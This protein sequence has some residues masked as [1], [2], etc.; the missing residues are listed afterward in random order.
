VRPRTRT[1]VLF[2]HHDPGGVIDPYVTHY[3]E[4]LHQ[5]NTDIIFVSTCPVL[6]P[7]SVAPIRDLCAAIYTR[8]NTGYDFGSWH[9]AWCL[10]RQASWS[11]DDFDC[12]VLANDSVYGPLFPLTEM[13]DTFH[14][15][16][17]YG[18]IASTEEGLH[19][20]SFFLAFDINPKTRGFLNKFWNQ[21]EHI[22]AAHVIE[23]YELG[24]SNSARTAGLRIKPFIT[25]TA[26]QAAYALAPTYPKFTAATLADTA[27]LADRWATSPISCLRAGGFPTR[28]NNTIYFWDG[29]IEHLR[30]PF[31]KTRIPR[32]NEPTLGLPD[33]TTII[34]PTARYRDIIEAHTAYPY[35]LIQ[36]NVDRHHD[37]TKARLS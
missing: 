8:Y 10:L 31:L 24:I 29:L 28:L 13:W 32:R 5:L 6:T 7:E 33:G 23:R 30:F 16:D 35:P 9:F 11:L 15:A 37:L 4:A 14:D 34:T 27:E 21:F 25:A 2:A 19:L 1:L 12:I 18:A 26:A 17:M 3:L 20:Q 36:A 22:N